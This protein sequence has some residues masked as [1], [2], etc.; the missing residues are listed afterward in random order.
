MEAHSGAFRSIPV[1]IRTGNDLYFCVSVIKN[2]PARQLMDP[3]RSIE[4]LQTT[5][6]HPKPPPNHPKPSPNHPKPPSNHPKPPSKHPN[7]IS[8]AST[9]IQGHIRPLPYPLHSLCS[10]T[11]SRDQR[12]LSN[13]YIFSSI[14]HALGTFIWFLTIAW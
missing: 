11:W 14:D 13:H 8:P 12:L 5:P 4:T 6:R 3:N 7:H 9:D 10:N 1:I 2:E